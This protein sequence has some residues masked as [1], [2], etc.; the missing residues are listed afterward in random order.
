MSKAKKNAIRTKNKAHKKELYD[1]LVRAWRERG[2]DHPN[3]RYS[4]GPFD[5]HAEFGTIRNSFWINF[6]GRH[7]GVMYSWQK[8]SHHWLGSIP[9]DADMMKLRL[10]G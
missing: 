9:T 8:R 10:Y 3:D 6:D 4:I 5:C 2:P 1:M 7:V